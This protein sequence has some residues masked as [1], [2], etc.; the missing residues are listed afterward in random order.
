MFEVLLLLLPP[1]LVLMSV[2]MRQRPPLLTME[3]FST[4]ATDER[5]QQRAWMKPKHTN[6]M[7]QTLDLPLQLQLHPPPLTP[8][9]Q[10]LTTK[11]AKLR[12][13]G[14]GWDARQNLAREAALM[15]GHTDRRQRWHRRQHRG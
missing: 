13:G 15:Q 6:Q 14:C 8:P 1:P 4:T 9:P 11:A 2:L 3:P 12:R 10:L 5:L 7:Q